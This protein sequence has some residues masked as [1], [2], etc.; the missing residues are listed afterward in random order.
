MFKRFHQDRHGAAAVEFALLGLVALTLILETM[1]VGFF[2]CCSVFLERATDKAMRA[3]QI[4]TV[5]A[6]GMSADQFRLNVFC[7]AL[8][9]GMSCSRV[10]LDIRT[11]NVGTS[12]AGYYA[13][14]K[15]DRSGLQPLP[16]D[17]SKTSFCPGAPSVHVFLQSFYAMPTISPFWTAL[18]SVSWNG[19]NV[20]FVA[21][22][23]VFKNEPFEHSYAATC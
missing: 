13:F 22:T 2:F 4:G 6:Q 16:M 1:Q 9:L 19:E 12:P 15:S 17:N 11:A 20:H 5:S 18:S 8:P 3:I 10:I 14:V 23:S 7:A 21:Q